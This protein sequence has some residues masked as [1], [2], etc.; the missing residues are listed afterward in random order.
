MPVI[1]IE[2]QTVQYESDRQVISAF[3]ARPYG[4]PRSRAPVAGASVGTP[5]YENRLAGA[6]EQPQTGAPAILLLHEWWGL[7]DQ[8]KS[9][10]RRFA[11]EGY[12]ALAPDLYACQGGKVTQDPQEASTLMSN[13]SSQRSLRD[14]NAA[15]SFLKAQPFVDALS[16]GAVGF[17]MGASLALIMAGHNSDLKAVVA[18]YG[19]VPLIETFKY[20]L[21]PILFHHA[22][23]DGWVTSQEVERL[24]QGFQQEGKPGEVAVYPDADHAFFNDTRPDVYRGGDAELAWRRTLS[25]L[26]QHVRQP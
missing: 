10:A 13:L 15:V 2:T 21:C 9:V 8:M 6:L 16:L 7:N 20:Q 4:A 11:E 22:G 14:L 12:V 26:G 5:K 3:L 1:T 24:R 23:K 17:S 18:F 19:K 25:F